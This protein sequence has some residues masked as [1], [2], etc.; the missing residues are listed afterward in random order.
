M[1]FMQNNTRFKDAKAFFIIFCTNCVNEKCKFRYVIQ[2]FS[3]CSLSKCCLDAF[4]VLLLLSTH[5]ADYIVGQYMDSSWSDE[6]IWDF[7]T[8]ITCTQQ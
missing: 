1:D 4:F 5:N 2:L 7:E 8:V 6:K 3:L